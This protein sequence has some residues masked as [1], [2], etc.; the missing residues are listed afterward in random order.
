MYIMRFSSGRGIRS[1]ISMSKII[2]IIANRKNRI[3]NGIRALLL[4]SKPHSKVEDVSFL[5]V[6][7]R[8]KVDAAPTTN[9]G[10]AIAQIEK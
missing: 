5:F 2:K 9:R 8:E 10:K 6:F 3:E 1:T 4:G 7:F